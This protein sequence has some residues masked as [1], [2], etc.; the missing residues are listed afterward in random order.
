MEEEKVA[1]LGLPDPHPVAQGL[2]SSSMP[3]SISQ[4]WNPTELG[5]FSFS[6]GPCIT[7]R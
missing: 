5:T 6:I 2:S 7:D 3:F 1:A 4:V